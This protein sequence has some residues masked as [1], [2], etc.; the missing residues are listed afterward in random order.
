MIS[1]Q[2]QSIVLLLISSTMSQCNVKSGFEI[3][4]IN[5]ARVND[6][7]KLVKRV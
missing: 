6:F 1:W 5:I 2:A 3:F 4:L 7:L